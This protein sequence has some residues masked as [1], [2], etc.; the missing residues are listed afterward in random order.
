MRI[1]RRSERRVLLT[2]RIGVALLL[3][4]LAVASPVLRPEPVSAASGVDDY[5]ARLKSAGLDA[6]VDP[7]QFYN[8]EC[9]SWVA[10]RLNSENQVAFT[11][12]WQGVHWGNASNWKYAANQLNIPV[13]NNA[14][15]GAVAWWAKGS[16]GSSRGHVAWVQTVSDN[17][18]TIEEYNYLR[19][20]FY[21]TRTIS[22]SSSMWPSG[23]IHIKDTVVRNTAAPA[24]TGT[25]QVGLKLVT[26][27]GTWSATN[28]VFHYQWLAN[29]VPI[30][31]ATTKAFKP[32][33]AQVGKRLRA[34]VTATKS[35]AHTGTAKSAAT[36]SVALGIFANSAAPAIAGKAQVGVPLSASNGT[37]SPVGAY[38]FRWYAD[39][40]PITGAKGAT[41]TPTAAQ[42]GKQLKV[43]VTSTLAGYSTQSATSL[44]TDAVAPGQFSATA[45]PTVSG[46]PQVDQVLTATAG[47]WAPAGTVAYQWLADGQP[48]TGAT[49]TTYTPTADDVRRTMSVRVTV[50]QLG[51][52]DAV[53]TAASSGPVIPG[54]LLNLRAPT[55]SGTAQVGLKLTADKGAWTPR[56]NVAYQWLADGVAVP[57]ATSVTYTVQPA[58]VGKHVAVEIIASRLGY[59]TALLPSVATVKVAPGVFHSTQA[60][61]VTGTAMFGHTL[62]ASAGTWSL[63]GVTPA[64]Q[65]YAGSTPITGAT[66]ATYDPRQADAG[67]RIHVVV[68][69][70]SPG[71]TAAT[72]TSTSTAPVLLGR[73]TVSKPTVTGRSVVG[74]RLEAHLESFGPATATPHFHWY[75]GHQRIRGASGATYVVR[76]ADVGQRLHVEVSLDPTNWVPIARHS[77]AGLTVRTVPRLHVRTSLRH[78]RVYL[79]LRVVSDGLTG[80][81]RGTARALSHGTGI[82]RWAVVDGVGGRL[83]APLRHGTHT[84][85][86]V[87]RGGALET[88]GRATVTVTV[89]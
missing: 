14:T 1:R 84:I 83:L 43:T 34:K 10:W 52:A 25:P 3:G 21:D 79:H 61:V 24:V 75:R 26:S 12:Y 77:T 16:A 6:L 33:A 2:R 8:R 11:D 67:Q 22:S 62:H 36:T 45:P 86:V 73:A 81:P 30:A 78:G 88:V 69:A 23:F 19:A 66:A 82:G 42:L 71:Y 9:T 54:T 38:A 72:A 87:Y 44:V 80:A 63:A 46:T 18:I 55:V 68:T 13:D 49:H 17:A 39:G 58:D 31:G 20:G 27:N 47:S 5:P 85:T 40:Q 15:R 60:P 51:Y 57:G 64:Y 35:G 50:H 53:A 32:S 70:S 41:F 59:L 76:S 7:W 29:G 28:L 74:R 56:A 65:W 48:V 4:A 37:W 89:P